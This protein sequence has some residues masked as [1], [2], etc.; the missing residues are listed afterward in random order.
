MWSHLPQ[1]IKSTKFGFKLK[2]TR[3]QTTEMNLLCATVLLSIY[4]S[5]CPPSQRRVFP[6]AASAITSD[7]AQPAES[8]QANSSQ[9][10]EAQ[11]KRQ[12]LHQLH[13]W[14]R[15]ASRKL[16]RSLN[17]AHATPGYKRKNMCILICLGLCLHLISMLIS[18]YKQREW[19]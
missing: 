3:K 19:M 5:F 13:L 9:T 8:F 12:Q 7:V 18:S 11:L 2:N 16:V 4:D 1:N 6:P 15:S 10:A 17:I 14:V